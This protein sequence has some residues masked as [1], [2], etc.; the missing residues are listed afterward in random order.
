VVWQHG[1]IFNISVSPYAEAQIE[2]YPSMAGQPAILIHAENYG[3]RYVRD[4]NR[5]VG[6]DTL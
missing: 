4:P 5:P 3:E 6:T 1:K 2:V